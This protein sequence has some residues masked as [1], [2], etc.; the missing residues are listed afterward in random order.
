M[1]ETHSMGLMWLTIILSATFSLVNLFLFIKLLKKLDDNMIV[2]SETIEL[3]NQQLNN[4]VK[5]VEV[6]KRNLRIVNNEVK[7]KRHRDKS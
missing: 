6:L 1:N 5:D 3:L 7:E 4:L 2:V